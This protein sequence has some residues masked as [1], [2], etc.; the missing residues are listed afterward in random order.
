VP[1]FVSGQNCNE[2]HNEALNCRI[3][4]QGS[5]KEIR[6]DDA[7]ATNEATPIATKNFDDL[8][9]LAA[10]WTTMP[11]HIRAAIMALVSTLKP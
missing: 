11:E 7:H 9:A 8:N 1:C 2:A 10:I 6:P 5:A 4:R 3:S